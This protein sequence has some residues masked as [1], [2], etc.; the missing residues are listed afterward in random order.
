MAKKQT[1]NKSK[2]NQ[3]Q[4]PKKLKPNT[5]ISRNVMLRLAKYV[6]AYNQARKV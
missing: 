3:G 2:N 4:E 6:T 5:I 1:K